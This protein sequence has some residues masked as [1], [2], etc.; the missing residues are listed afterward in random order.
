ML[1][2]I[3]RRSIFIKKI[4]NLPSQLLPQKKKNYQHWFE[5]LCPP[6][7]PFFKETKDFFVNI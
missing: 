1:T 2:L 3:T 7:K 5:H 4:D 6:F